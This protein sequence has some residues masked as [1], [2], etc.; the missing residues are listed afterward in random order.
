MSFQRCLAIVALLSGVAA[1]VPGVPAPTLIPR[2]ETAAWVG[3]GG[4]V[5]T[6]GL[7]L[8]G[9]FSR[10]TRDRRVLRVRG[11]IQDNLGVPET[12]VLELSVLIGRGHICCGGRQWGAYAI[13]GG[14]VSGSKGSPAEDFTTVGL[15]GE[16]MLVTGKL[17]HI[18]ISLMGNLNS[19]VPF[20]SANFALLLGRMPFISSAP[21]RRRF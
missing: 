12:S 17:P 18:S 20:L 6:P 8:Q 3:I 1:C 5:G 11:N 9:D 2:S 21:V 13:G 15:A 7:G 14:I 4:T 16:L 10:V 19:E